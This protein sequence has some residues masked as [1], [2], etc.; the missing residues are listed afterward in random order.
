MYVVTVTI[1][2]KDGRI[3]DFMPLMTKNARA[4][5]ADEDECHQFDVCRDGHEV[6]L[7]E[8]Y[9]NRAAF[10]LH[11]ESEHFLTFDT[12]IAE[13]VEARAVRVYDEVHR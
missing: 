1:H 12:A 2:I 5:L 6:F 13:M 7:Y 9:E 3:D 10:E 4:S 11:L 8:V